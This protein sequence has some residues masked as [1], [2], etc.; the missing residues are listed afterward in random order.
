LLA[1]AMLVVAIGTVVML[2]GMVRTVVL[3]RRWR[4]RPESRPRGPVATAL[5]VGLPFV[6]NA[7]WGLTLLFVF[8]QLAYPLA[9]TM[10]IVPD[11]GY[12]VVASGVTALTW[13]IVRTVLAYLTLRQ[14]VT[15]GS[16]TSAGSGQSAVVI[17]R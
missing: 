13:S 16:G 2:L 11:L 12:L 6:A 1:P 4:T 5:R 3:L 9:P 14:N 17:G 8:P 10:L 7:A 15:L